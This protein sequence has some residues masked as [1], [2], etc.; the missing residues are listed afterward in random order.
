M[1]RGI[2]IIKID[3]IK[4]IIKMFLRNLI[5]VYIYICCMNILSLMCVIVY[6]ILVF[7]YWKVEFVFLF[8]IYVLLIMGYMVF[9]LCIL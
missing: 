2:Y 9:F 7:V 5:Y 3:W 8:K 1:I 4:F 6:C